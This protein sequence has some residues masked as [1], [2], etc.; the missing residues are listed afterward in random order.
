MAEITLADYTGY[1]FLE[2]IKARQMADEYSR[3][4]A[5][6]YAKDPVLRFFLAPRFKV[7]KM[8][9]TV[10]VL[11]SGARFQ[12]V[13]RF[14][15]PQEKFVS[16]ILGRAR[17]V[18]SAVLV[19]PN[20]P[21]KKVGKKLL[22]ATSLPGATSRIKDMANDFFQQLTDNI[23][24]SQPGSIVQ[25]SWVSIFEKA[26]TMESMFD[27]YKNLYPNNE[28]FKQSLDDVLRMVTTN[29]VIDRTTIQNLLINPETNI[30]KNGSSDSSVFTIKVEMQE[31]G[32]FIRE[33]KD[34]DTGQTRRIV[35]FE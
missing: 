35:E 33:I 23:D 17:E 21:F 12:Q 16:F 6:S 5:E 10:P 8:E 19:R 11:I 24:P 1:I 29:T 7:P 30:V 25:E 15:M 13:F 20:D 18:I 14:N 2:I 27:A 3:Q 31:E 4:I 26:L 28:L 9:L 34:E 32:F 22:R